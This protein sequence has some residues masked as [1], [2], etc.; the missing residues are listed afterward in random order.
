MPVNPFFNQTAFVPEQNLIQDLI[1]ESIQ[2]H[3]HDTYYLM[4]DDVDLDALFGEDE[5]AS[6]TSARSI[7]MFIKSNTG[8]QGQSEFISKFGLQIEDQCTFTVSVRRFNS[9]LGTVLTRPR[10]GD[11]IWLQMSP[12][13]RYLFEIRFV[14]DK[15]QLFQL[16]KLYTYEIR[17][18]LMNYSHERV[19]TGN[20]VIDDVAK[21]HAYTLEI[22]VE[23]GAGDYIV[24]E[25]VYQGASFIEAVATGTV[26][27]WTANTNILAVQNITG[28]F[29][30]GIQIVGF[31]SS[32][33]R[34]S[35]DSPD[36]SPIVHDPIAD[37][38][39]LESESDS[40]IV[41]RGTNPRRA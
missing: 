22:N 34:L 5:L 10:E 25:T 21:D 40:V 12:T 27:D 26:S 11:I 15:E 14:E 13:N 4:R 20:D 3:G 37:N 7:E 1:D 8:F 2:I 30:N 23:A 17:C 16:G 29:A 31:N 36:T 9:V 28:T 6:Y 41:I 18:E 39:L 32:T 35:V 19:Q 33:V 24:G 38:T